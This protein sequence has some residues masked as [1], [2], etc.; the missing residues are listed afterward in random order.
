MKKTLLLFVV[1]FLFINHVQYGQTPNQ[2]LIFAVDVSGSMRQPPGFFNNLKTE[3]K[4]YIKNNVN[5]NDL[6]TIYSFGTDVKIIT[7]V[8]NYKITG[9]QDLE[10]LLEYVDKLEPKDQYTWLTKAFDNVASLMET[11]QKEYPNLNITAFLFTDGKNDPPIGSKELSL[12]EI[13][14]KYNAAFDNPNTYTYIITLDTQVDPEIKALADSSNNV[15][16]LQD[17]KNLKIKELNFIPRYQQLTI[18][19]SNIHSIEAAFQIRSIKNIKS[20]KLNFSLIGQSKLNSDNNEFNITFDESSPGFNIP[21]K[22]P[23]DI[24]AGRYDLKYDVK[25]VNGNYKVNPKEVTIELSIVAP[26]L[27]IYNN[28]IEVDAS[29]KGGEIHFSLQG[30]NNSNQEINLI[31]LLSPFDK[32]I[33][34]LEKNVSLP[35]GK[36]DKEIKIALEPKIEGSYNYD[37]SFRPINQDVQINKT[38]KLVLILTKPFNWGPIL[39]VLLIL[40]IVGV[41]IGLFYLY[42][43]LVD[44][45]FSK[46]SIS[47]MG[48]QKEPLKNFKKFWQSKLT[49]GTDIFSDV[50]GEKVVT[51]KANLKTPIDKKL[52]L[53]WHGTEENI[54]PKDVLNL[55]SLC[56]MRVQYNRK[57]QFELELFN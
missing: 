15:E 47:G 57:Y 32:E 24:K 42:F 1:F 25:T 55:T 29:T 40:L 9:T 31:P 8:P 36:F 4:K 23:Q 34:F 3:I 7:D 49:I 35:P 53:E 48:L 6:V 20:G 28:N 22:L 18:D 46:Y 17:T 50:I 56:D 19:L 27:K 21:L 12:K 44:K 5:I 54:Q 14:K 45:E 11:T 52:I 13:F 51:I 43:F 33:K 37:L 10:R 30:E 2:A 26:A 41:I 39:T 38:I 16:V